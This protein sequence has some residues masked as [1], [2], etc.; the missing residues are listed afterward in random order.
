M[1]MYELDSFLEAYNTK[2]KSSIERVRWAHYLY[3]T[4]NGAKVKSPKDIIEFSWEKTGDTEEVV[5][6]K[7]QIRALQQKMIRDTMTK[8]FKPV[9]N[10]SE[11]NHL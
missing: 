6:T 1:T 7:E 5:M 11:I 3:L 9:K 4:A 2:E 8:K 10:I